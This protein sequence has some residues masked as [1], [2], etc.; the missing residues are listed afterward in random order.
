MRRC[1]IVAEG[2]AVNNGRWQIQVIAVRVPIKKIDGPVG[3]YVGLQAG[4]RAKKQE[5]RDEVAHFAQK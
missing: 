2:C 5:Q 1:K 4:Q 3:A